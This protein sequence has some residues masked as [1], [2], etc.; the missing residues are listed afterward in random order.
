MCF[1]NALIGVGCLLLVPACKP[2]GPVGLPAQPAQP[3]PGETYTHQ[4]SGFHFPPK[5]GAFAR[6]AVQQYD[7]EGQDISVGYNLGQSAAM[8]VY[9]YPPQ[10]GAPDKSLAGQF[11]TCK[12]EIVGHHAGAKQT[13]AGPITATVGGQERTGRRAAYTLTEP[14][15]ARQQELGSELYLFTEGKWFIKYRVTYSAGERETVEPAIKA[16]I[17]DLKWPANAKVGS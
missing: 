7:R 17:T 9:V 6:E 12:N 3:A 10:P 11:E 16:F 15:A 2:T 1:R 8:T 4:P 14:S 13:F 5:V